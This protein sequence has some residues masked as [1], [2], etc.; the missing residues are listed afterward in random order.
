MSRE[1]HS[2][3]L[4]EGLWDRVPEPLSFQG[5][6]PTPHE[7]GLTGFKKVD[8]S[9]P[10]SRDRGFTHGLHPW[11]AKFI[12]D[13]PATAISLLSEP[14][15]TVLD[16]FCGCGTA[17]VEAFVADRGFVASDVN[18]LAVLITEGK[19]EV[20]GPNDRLLIAKWAETLSPQAVSKGTFVGGTP[21]S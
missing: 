1:T 15:E 8:W 12:P 7:R 14:G 11:P 3:S 6:L 21:D 20:P 16:P 17:A 18:P 4:Q 2:L 13:V 19:C 10:D 5:A 9:F